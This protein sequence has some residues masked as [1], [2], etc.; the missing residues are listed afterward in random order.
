MNDTSV[1]RLSAEEMLHYRDLAC[2]YAEKSLR[3]LFDGEYPDGNLSVLKEKLD[4]ALAIGIAASA[5]RSMEGSRYGIWGSATGE[6][7][8]APSIMLLSI[9][10]ETCGG[11]AMCLHVQGLASHVL[12][13]T[14]RIPFTPARPGLCLQE[15]SRPPGLGTIIDPGADRPAKIGTTAVIKGDSYVISGTKAFVHSMDAADAYV[16]LARTGGDWGCFLVPADNR[17]VL[18]AGTGVRTGLRACR[19]EEVTFADT[20]VPLD[21]RIDNGGARALVIRALTLN[22]AGMCAIAAGIAR[23]AVA[24]ARR[25]ASER[26]QGGA[27]IEEL[28][29]VQ[30]LIAG[31]EAAACTA[32]ASLSP[33]HGCN[34]SSPESLGMA[35][36]AKL[37]VMELCCRAVTDCLQVFGGYG[38][39]EDFGMEKRLRDIAVLKCSSGPPTYLKQMVFE[40]GKDKAR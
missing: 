16:V 1:N 35:A 11:V 17:R 30:Q 24:A 31:S 34:P 29:A 40:I 26:Y 18:I 3:P 39:M 32:E 13:Q 6:L 14:D 28:P 7:G 12:L 38:Y 2:L 21:A 33:L 20:T 25:Y 23:G 4:T 37:T 5:D 22:W 27:L 8:L 9:I 36:A 15:G 10:A 19:V